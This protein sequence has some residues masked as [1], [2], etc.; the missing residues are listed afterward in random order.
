MES[1]AYV[2]SHHIELWHGADV[3]DSFGVLCVIDPSL[4]WLG[5]QGCAGRKGL[6][7]W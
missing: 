2:C 3:V 1:W 4:C 6:D 7:H 5:L